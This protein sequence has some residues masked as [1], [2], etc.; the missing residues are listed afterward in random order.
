V[1]IITLTTDFGTRDWFVGAMKGVILGIQPQAIIVDLAHDVG[2]GDIRGGAFSLMAGY[3]LFS[4]GTVH[5]AVIDPG[6][7]SARQAI[8]VKTTNHLFVGPDNGVL[9]FAL[10]REKIKSIRRL[11]NEKFF[12][13]PVSR[14]FHGRDIFAPVAAHLSRSVAF[15]KFGPALEDFVRLDWPRVQARAGKTEGE[16]VYVDRFGN[17]ITNIQTES[18]QIFGD[19]PCEVFAG[20]KRLCPIAPFYGAVPAGRPLAVMGSTGLLEIAINGAS[21]AEKFRLG[22]GDKLDVRP[23]IK[24]R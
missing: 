8:A 15:E 19:K 1:N 13:N 21:A 10:A 5:V 11:E 24:S 22:V 23:W 2:S 12:L 9:S 18:L 6:V 14:T 17:L 4:K 20:R 3:S 7:G 16:I